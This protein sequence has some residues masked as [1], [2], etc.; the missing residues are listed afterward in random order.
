[1]FL[2]D[3]DPDTDPDADGS[4]TIM[5]IAG[6][7]VDPVVKSPHRCV[8]N[9]RGLQIMGGTLQEQKITIEN[10]LAR[11]NMKKAIP[12]LMAIALAGCATPVSQASDPVA[13]SLLEMVVVEAQDWIW[14]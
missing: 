8:V 5:R 14:A 1:L 3:T 11:K 6:F 12:L 13:D 10:L 4:G 7:W 2:F 9:I